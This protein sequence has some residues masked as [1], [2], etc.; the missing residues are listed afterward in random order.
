MV[1]KKI[2]N[3]KK[4]AR[5]KLID[6][7]IVTVSYNCHEYLIDCLESLRQDKISNGLN[8]EVIVVDN[9]STDGTKKMIGLKKYAWV[10]WIEAENHG[11]G[12][13]NNLGLKKARGKYIFLLNPDTKIK[14]GNLWKLF[15]YME[16]H[17]GVG[18]VAPKL[19]FGDGSLQV[20]AFDAFPGLISGWLENTLFDRFFYWLWP[21]KIYPGKLFSKSLHDQEREVAHVLGAAMFC[22]REVYECAGGF[23]ERFFLFR[24]ETDWQR[25]I[26]KC[27]YK[28]VFWPEVV[29]KHF[30]GKSTGEARLKS[31][32][33]MRKLNWYLPSV[34]KYQKKWHGDLST[35]ILICFY[36][37][38]SIWTLLVL[39]VIFVV[40]NLLL[41]VKPIWRSKINKSVRSIAIYH[42]AIIY[43]HLG[44]F[45]RMKWVVEY[46]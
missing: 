44:R 25:R 36:F 9:N 12:A 21:D 26:R 11:Y 3:P 27:G 28:I 33:W 40:N 1:K 16:T 45:S 10:K 30:E 35:L 14:K 39:G 7:S 8:I 32:N 2:T 31:E 20:N 37:F 23:D 6:I 38:G 18:I 19:V 41:W 46:R 13:G 29:I 22:R 4:F 24:E 34:Y 17:E 42:W 43:W 5:D 15:E